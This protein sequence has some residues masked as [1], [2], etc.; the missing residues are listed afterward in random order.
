M[1]GE[2]PEF[3]PEH[4][5]PLT[6]EQKRL[7]MEQHLSETQSLLESAVA[8]PVFPEPSNEDLLALRAGVWSIRIMGGIPD[9]SRL[10]SGAEKGHSYVH[11]RD[12]Y[13]YTGDQWTRMEIPFEEPTP[14]PPPF[15]DSSWTVSSV[16][17]WPPYKEK[18]IHNH[19][20]QGNY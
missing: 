3:K 1:S 15:E 13:I 8:I 10:P 4:Y 20:Y 12:L 16:T 6:P 19:P 18:T 5:P 17:T 2:W 9:V 14:I 7:E 11:G